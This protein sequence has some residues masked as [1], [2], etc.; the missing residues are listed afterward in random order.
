[1][2]VS[3]KSVAAHGTTSAVTAAAMAIALP[4]IASWEG[5]DGLVAKHLAIDP[6][7]V[8]TVC[9]GITNYDI[10]T[11][12]EG[13][14]YSREQCD[15]MFAEHLLHYTF[16]ID[17]CVKVEVPAST[18]ASLYSAG[19]NLGAGR[20]CASNIVR[21]INAGDLEGGCEVLLQYIKANGVVL[22]GL[23]RRR[24]AEFKLCTGTA[25]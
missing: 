13:D 25:G 20:V 19:Y 4:F 1:M 23:Q 24:A 16:T 14:T 12:K 15:Q 22:R 5:D 10:P 2:P 3:T 6:P 7:G 18:R 11:L 9:Q 21:K 17:N 8:I